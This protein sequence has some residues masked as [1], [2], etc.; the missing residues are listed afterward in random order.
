MNLSRFEETINALSYKY[1]K[2][3]EKKVKIIFNYKQNKDKDFVKK[4]LCNEGIKKQI[5]PNEKVEEFT[6][7]IKNY[8]N[9]QSQANKYL[10]NLKE[11]I[12]EKVEG[13]L[14]LEFK[15]DIEYSHH[16]D[17]LAMAFG[18]LDCLFFYCSFSYLI[19]FS[20]P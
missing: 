13:N 14:P 8:F 15:Y 5:I 16:D 19:S 1:F 9:T 20:R 10:V 7:E 18:L 3:F 4:L 6:N 12:L 2:Y 17:Q 11:R